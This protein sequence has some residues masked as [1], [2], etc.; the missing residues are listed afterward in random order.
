MLICRECRHIFWERMPTPDEVAAYYTDVYSAT[1]GQHD[2]Q[3]AQRAYYRGH[4]QELA[5]LAGV[6]IERM[7]IA[8]VGCS[9]PS[10]AE[11]A[12]GAG[13]ALAFGVD[14]SEDARTDGISRRVAVLT[15]EEFTRLIPDGFVDVLRYSHTLEHLIDPVA[16]L[17]EQVA[18]VRPGGL[19]YITQPN[20]PVLRWTNATVAP[21]DSDFPTHLQ[22]FNPLSF[23]RLAEAADL[24]VTCYFSV[25]DPEV[26]QQ[27]YGELIDTSH[28]RAH[29]ADWAG[30]GEAV[31][32]PLNNF[33]VYAGLDGTGH[34]R[35]A[36][37]P[38]PPPPP[39]PPDW[40][41]RLWAVFD[42]PAP[43]EPPPPSDPRGEIL[44]VIG[45]LQRRARTGG[46]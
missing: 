25:T 5:G 2:I 31:R 44:T 9:F 41:A 30:K 23:R 40:R 8:D 22:F 26:G 18:K 3:E 39:P 29:L 21:H 1:A 32:G 12:M 45:T 13:A 14:W 6:P 33:P 27:R 11:E 19:V 42:P 28:A 10:F 34:L 20:F 35:V 24:E 15:P 38:P 7:V 46:S 17:R 36:L 43:P 4:A 16:T 37:P